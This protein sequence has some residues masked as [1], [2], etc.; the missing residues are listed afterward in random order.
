VIIIASSF[1]F[2]QKKGKEG[3]IVVKRHLAAMF[4]VSAW[5]T[6]AS[7]QVL[8]PGFETAGANSSLAAGWT[9]D[10]AGGGPVY[11]VRT[12]TNPHSGSFHYEIHLASTGAGP[13]VQFNQSSVV[14]VGGVIY[15]FSFYSDRLTGSSGDNSEYNIQWLNSNST[16]VGSTGYIGF[17]PGNNAYAQTVVTGLTAPVTAAKANI[18]FHGAGAAITN[19]SATIDFDD[20]SL[21]TTNNSGGGGGGGGITNQVQAGII[22]MEAINWFASNG[23]AY[24]V[25][26]SSDNATWNNLGTVTTGTGGSNTVY[27]TFGQAG[28]NFYQV[29]S[30][31]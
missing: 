27:D 8:N 17:T 23:V 10:T 13:V 25:Q 5:A 31:Q 4:A 14:V 29:L 26:W 19:Q 16:V 9:T 24:Q 30:I 7:A 11:C 6:L 2:T 21:S 18:F 12:N 20:V 15:T 28:H 1:F 22:R 3:S